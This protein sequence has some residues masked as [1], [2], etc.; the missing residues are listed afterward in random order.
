ME[1]ITTATPDG[2]RVSVIAIIANILLMAS[3]ITVGVLFRSVGLIA[4]GV[5]SLADIFGVGVVLIGLRVSS[6][7]ADVEH[8][9]GH[10]KAEPIAEL[11][12]AFIVILTG[13]FIIYD[14]ITALLTKSVASEVQIG[15]TVAGISTVTAWVLSHYKKRVGNRIKSSA[16]I[17]ESKH[18]VID[19]VSSL[20]VAAGLILTSLGFWYMDPIVGIVISMLIIQIGISVTRTSVDTLMDKEAPPELRERIRKAI[21]SVPEVKGVNY[22]HSRGSWNYKIVDASI[23]VS[24]GLTVSDISALQERIKE[25]I[26]SAIPEVHQVNVMVNEYTDIITV[27]ASSNGTGLEAAF[28]ND[29]GNCDYFVIATVQKDAI[30][31]VASF[32]NPYKELSRKKGAKIADFMHDHKVDVVITGHAGEGAMQWLRG[33][34][35]NIK[36]V[37]GSGLRVFDAIN[38]VKLF[39]QKN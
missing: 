14:S 36:V 11:V 21:E 3:K 18:S 13:L 5:H 9:Y 33:Y 24:R 12:V 28:A 25:G 15:I 34:G 10:S 29:L 38:S 23:T 27:A 7:P 30:N 31:V 6:R 17:A 37:D 16:L 32:E 22:V 8:P 39:A 35:I 2:T 4:D 20:S 26:F 19:A 1:Q